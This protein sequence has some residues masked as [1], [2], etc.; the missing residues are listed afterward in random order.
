MSASRR[1]A[2]ITAVSAVLLVAVVVVHERRENRRFAE[3][4]Q[5][6]DE[7]RVLQSMGRDARDLCAILP[8]G[9]DDVADRVANRVLAAMAMGGAG[10]RGSADALTREKQAEAEPPQPRTLEQ[11]NLVSQ[12]EQ[13]AERAIRS[14]QLRRSDVLELRDIFSRVG[15][16]GATEQRQLRERIVKAVNDQK[17]TVEDPMYILF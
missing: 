8:A 9:G 1:P 5:R 4:V 14:G 3:L 15:D 13:I 11:Q 12:A 17:L 2:W 10:V 7:L 16:G 6:I